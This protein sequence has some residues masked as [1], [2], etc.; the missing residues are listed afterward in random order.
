MRSSKTFALIEP[1]GLAQGKRPA[2]RERKAAGFTLIELLVVIAIVALL[3]SILVPSLKKARELAKN[4]VCMSQLHGLGTMLQMYA[5]EYGT[6]SPAT[7][8][9]YGR[10]WEFFYEQRAGGAEQF[11][12]PSN[13]VHG[14]SLLACDNPPW[15][16]PGEDSMTKVQGDPWTS[17][18]GWPERGGYGW[19]CL[20]V[21]DRWGVRGS[22]AWTD[23]GWYDGNPEGGLT[24]FS[25]LALELADNSAAIWL[26][27]RAAWWGALNV[28]TDQVI[29]Q[30]STADFAAEPY[31]TGSPYAT[32]KFAGSPGDHHQ[33]DFNALHLDG[34]SRRWEY[35]T[36]T[37]EDW[38]VWTQ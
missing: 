3:V 21:G 34:G 22:A 30:K 12:C 1:F 9:S 37:I 6:T 2:V 29:G 36:T 18:L 8:H 24:D 33:G 14:A 28:T 25:G 10:R 19:N 31:V 7:A 15:G 32:A 4:A 17:V 23:W 27:C 38:T 13:P 35:G 5:S 26:Y 16:V 20:K 11:W